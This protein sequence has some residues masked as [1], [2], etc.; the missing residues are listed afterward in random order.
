[1]LTY[2]SEDGWKRN[3]SR[4][5]I[6]WIMIGASGSGKSTQVDKIIMSYIRMQRS[7]D[8]LC[9]DTRDY[10]Q[11][12]SDVVFSADK[13]FTKEDAYNFVPSRLAEAH[14][15]CIK[16]FT[17]TVSQCYESMVIVDNTNT[18]IAQISPYIAVAKAFGYIV[19]IIYCS[20]QNPN[21]HDVPVQTVRFQRESIQNML[22]DWPPYWPKPHEYKGSY[23]HTHMRVES[24]KENK[25]I[26]IPGA[27]PTSMHFGNNRPFKI[28]D[29]LMRKHNSF[30]YARWAEK[31]SHSFVWRGNSNYINKPVAG[32][33]S[34]KKTFKNF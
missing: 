23:T 25:K 29:P 5:K 33:T 30:N 20:A 6:C 14:E 1:M 26:F 16:K 28:T 31:L 24:S 10:S 19:N 7:E 4:E 2:N 18:S 12:F 15:E 8:I 13:F 34:N 17:M 27:D 21:R 22:M 3:L 32:A 9:K 11:L